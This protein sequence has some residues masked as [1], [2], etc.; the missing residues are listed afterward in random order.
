MAERVIG[1]RA[2]VS[3][4]LYFDVEGAT[5]IEQEAE[6][7]AALLLWGLDDPGWDSIGPTQAQVRGVRL[8]VDSDPSATTVRIVD[9]FVEHA[10]EE[11][12]DRGPE[13][14]VLEVNSGGGS[15]VE[16]L[17]MTEEGAMERAIAW[18]E[19][20]V[21]E[22]RQDGPSATVTDMLPDRLY[23]PYLDL[24]EEHGDPEERLTAGRQ[25]LSFITD[26]R[27]GVR[28]SRRWVQA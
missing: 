5:E 20:E 4:L 3:A 13:C 17:F 19:S 6:A 23:G 7:R 26:N 14:W 9:T 11:A 2:E 21:E 16:G 8:A 18:I 28:I 1:G 12:A 15:S 22:W 27:G 25:L 24:K 10:E